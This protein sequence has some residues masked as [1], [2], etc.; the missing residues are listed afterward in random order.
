MT[1]TVKMKRKRIGSVLNLN[2]PRNSNTRLINLR[3]RET[4]ESKMTETGTKGT[5]DEVVGEADQ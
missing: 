3:I 4:S 5:W 2:D 1:A